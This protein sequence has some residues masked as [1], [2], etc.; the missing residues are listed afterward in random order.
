MRRLGSSQNITEL[1]AYGEVEPWGKEC[2]LLGTI[3]QLLYDSNRGAD[4][5]PITA[6]QFLQIEPPEDEPE[7]YEDEFFALAE[8]EAEDA[9]F[10]AFLE[11]QK[12]KPIKLQSP[13]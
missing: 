13:S 11:R 1:L 2:W 6:E 5:E 3:C 12:I 7:E 4:S 8:R 10:M 9:E